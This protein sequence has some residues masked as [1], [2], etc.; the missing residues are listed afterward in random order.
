MTLSPR[1]GPYNSIRSVVSSC[2]WKVNCGLNR[3]R[4]GLDLHPRQNKARWTGKSLR[5][6]S[7]GYEVDPGCKVYIRQQ[8]IL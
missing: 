4:D 6:C 2:I 3:P 1:L 7:I 5:V 8:R